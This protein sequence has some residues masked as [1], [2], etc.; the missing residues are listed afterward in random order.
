M[1]DVGL[2]LETHMGRGGGFPRP[3]CAS[4]CTDVNRGGRLL[5]PHQVGQVL[6]EPEVRVVGHNFAGFDLPVI[7]FHRPEARHAV[8]DA[9]SSGRVVDTLTVETLLDYA[10]GIFIP[11]KPGHM[12]LDAV[13]K[14]YGLAGKADDEWRERYGLLDGVAFEAWP[15]E[16]RTYAEVDAV[17]PLL[18]WRA[19]Q[20]RAARMG[21]TLPTLALEVRAA[22]TLSI[23]GSVGMDVDMSVGRHILDGFAREMEAQRHLLIADGLLRRDGRKVDARLR[24]IVAG[25]LG[26]SAPRTASGKVKADKDTIAA[27][28]NLPIIA[29]YKK[30]TKAEKLS[31]FVRKLVDAGPTIQVGYRPLGARSSRTSSGGGAAGNIQ[32]IPK[33]KRIRAILRG[34]DGGA[35]I[36]GDFSTQEMRTFAATCE[37]IVGWSV[38][39]SGFR[40]SRDFDPHRLLGA[41]LPWSPVF[42]TVE[43]GARQV[44]KSGNFAFLGGMREKGFQLYLRR[45]GVDM[46]LAECKT[47]LDGFLGAWREAPLFFEY[48]QS[49]TRRDCVMPITLP[50]SGYRR[51]DCY[52]TDACNL[53]FQA[54]AAHASKHAAWEVLRRCLDD[55]L[56][57]PLLGCMP[58]LFVHDEVAVTAPWPP[59]APEVEAAAAE[60]GRVMEAAHEE[61]TPSVP[62]KVD[63]R[64]GASWAG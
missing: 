48:V 58:C 3:V 62:A 26:P 42:D 10:E 5:Y 39:A 64:A 53:H 14:R 63:A 56:Q 25:V 17:V 54:L 30:Y 20:S 29:A 11:Q 32:Q 6:A 12:T 36:C 55:R 19:Q 49:I 13:A 1:I 47:I 31:Q 41:Q 23:T 38:L 37:A 44:A 52:Y 57:S 46:T 21:Y 2:D 24:E 28:P 40:S 7:Y 16:A 43:G 34:R 50:T 4:I 27:L 33:D 9:L 18:V 51:G 59:G 60:L 22:F 61:V 45:T 8:L 15:V 35:M